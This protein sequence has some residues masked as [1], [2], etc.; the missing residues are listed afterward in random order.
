MNKFYDY[1]GNFIA[2]NSTNSDTSW[3]KVGSPAK[4]LSVDI[5]INAIKV[6]FSLKYGKGCSAE[7]LATQQI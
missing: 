1:K 3:L 5:I 6:C 4:S 7:Q 2:S